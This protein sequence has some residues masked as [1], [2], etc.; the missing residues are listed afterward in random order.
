MAMISPQTAPDPTPSA[1][2][3]PVAAA[4][5][6][7]L[8][9]SSTLAVRWDDLDAEGRRGALEGLISSARDLEQLAGVGDGEEERP[10]FDLFGTLTPRE[11]EILQALSAGASTAS[12]ARSFGIRESTVRSHVKSILSKLGV[13]S[14]IEAIAR[15]SVHQPQ[16]RLSADS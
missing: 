16:P 13:H 4:L 9:N 3:R 5:R 6:A 8:S 7:L 10:G 14:R 1:R 11:A 2:V 15:A 12:I